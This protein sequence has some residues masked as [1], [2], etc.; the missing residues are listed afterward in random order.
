[1]GP[2]HVLGVKKSA[3]VIDRK[4]VASAP[5][6]KRVRNCMKTKGLDGNSSLEASGRASRRAIISRA[7]SG[8]RVAQ[9][10]G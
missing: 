5:L 8:V 3:E 1:M 7:H 4:E 10:R 2:S 6:R 9:V